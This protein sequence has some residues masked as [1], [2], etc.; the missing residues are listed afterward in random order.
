MLALKGTTVALEVRTQTGTD[1]FNRPIYET[2]FED[3]E[4]VLIAPVN[5]TEM[6]DTLN[7]TGRKAV[8]QLAIPKGDTHEWE[9][10]RVSFWGQLWRVIGIPTEGMDDLIPLAWNK[11]VQVESIVEGES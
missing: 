8:Y 3:V 4:N 7:L 11:K 2:S 1:E 6:L 5:S 9:N 10:C